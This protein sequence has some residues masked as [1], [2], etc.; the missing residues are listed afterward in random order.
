MSLV[1][2][3]AFLDPPVWIFLTNYSTALQTSSKYHSSHYTL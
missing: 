3:D 1:V 2:F